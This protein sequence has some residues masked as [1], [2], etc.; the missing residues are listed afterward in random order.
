MGSKQHSHKFQL[1]AIDCRVTP[2]V[3]QNYLVILICATLVLLFVP[4]RFIFPFIVLDFFTKKFQRKGNF[5]TRLLE[6][7]ELPPEPSALMYDA[8]Y[9]QS[10][11]NESKS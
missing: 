2:D 1:W 6:S 5:F 10:L 7:I 3:S 9:S 8:A 11:E 4:F